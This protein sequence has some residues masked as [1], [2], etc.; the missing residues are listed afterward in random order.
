VGAFEVAEFDE[1]MVEEAGVAVG[2]G[3]VAFAG[4]DGELGSRRVMPAPQ[5]RMVRPA[6]TV[7]P[8]ERRAPSGVVVR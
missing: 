1:L 8:S 7:V 2:D 4:F 6:D 3:E 5:A